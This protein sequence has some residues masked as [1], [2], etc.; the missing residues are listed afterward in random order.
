MNELRNPTTT[1]SRPRSAG[2]YYA[3]R[4]RRA[5]VVQQNLTPWT[6]S[7]SLT[8]AQGDYVQN[9]GNAYIALNSGMTAGDGP[10]QLIGN[11]TDGGGVQ[12]QFVPTTALIEFINVA[13][14]TPA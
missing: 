10:T 9:V 3:R 6:A 13:P 1:Q 11:F 2:M 8:V 12:W 4:L 7:P 5:R 14:P